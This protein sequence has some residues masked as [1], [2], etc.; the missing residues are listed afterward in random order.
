MYFCLIFQSESHSTKK[1]FIY[2]Y[3][4][5][6]IY[7]TCI[8]QIMYFRKLWCQKLILERVNTMSKSYIS[9]SN[10]SEQFYNSP[11]INMKLVQKLTWLAR[12][13]RNK[14]NAALTHPTNLPSLLVSSFQDR[15]ITRTLGTYC[16][17]TTVFSN[18]IRS[19]C[20]IMV[21]E[22][23]IPYTT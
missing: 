21:P 5:I 8:K 10:H 23:S 19:E 6:Y 17:R 3:I 4:Y 2:I 20:L 22:K 11:I 16:K 14:Q 13:Y 15:Q 9:T 7:N 1:L 18:F 12:M